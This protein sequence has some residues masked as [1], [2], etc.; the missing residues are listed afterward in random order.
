MKYYQQVSIVSI[1]LALVPFEIGL[2]KGLLTS[3]GVTCKT[4]AFLIR[5]R[6][7]YSPAKF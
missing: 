7:L 2:F 3:F 5:N 6:L 4:I 1:L